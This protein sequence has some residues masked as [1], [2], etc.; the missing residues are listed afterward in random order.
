MPKR[1][2]TEE[3]RE[4]L[5]QIFPNLELISEYKNDKSYVTVRCT[6][7][8]YTFNSKPVWLRHGH[9]CQKCYDDRRGNSLRRNLDDVIAHAKEVHGDK[10]DYSKIT[11]YKNGYTKV[12]IICPTHGEFMMTLNHHIRGQGCPKCAGKYKTTKEV[13]S[14]FKKIHKED[15]IYDKVNYINN[16]TKVC[17]ICPKHGEFWQ[18]P[19]KHLQGEGCPI[20][21]SS[22]LERDVRNFLIEN[23]IEFERQKNFNWLGKQSLDFYL[24]KHNMAIECQGEQHFKEFSGNL[25]PKK[26]IDERIRLDITKNELCSEN[27]VKMLYVMS[28]RWKDK[29]LTKK[30]NGIY[31]NNNT[32]LDKELDKI[33]ARLIK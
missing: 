6:I 10:Y 22:K 1:K 31:T 5:K 30:F 28:K 29:S 33:K 25:T 24:P 21:K 27:N 14:E 15:Y 3:F 9:G 17:I 8:N 19:D 23:N 7:H 20:C 11:T 4:E 16:S 12:P 32:I 18:T 26:S 2:T 13:I